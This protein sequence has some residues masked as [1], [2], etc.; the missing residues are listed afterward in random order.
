MHSLLIIIEILIIREPAIFPHK[1]LHVGP[2]I[3]KKH[4]LIPVRI[5][6]HLIV[7]QQHVLL[8]V[9]IHIPIVRAPFILRHL[10][11]IVFHHHL[12]CKVEI[13]IVVVIARCLS[14]CELLLLI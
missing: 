4:I 14:L 9:L 7:I 1:I 2:I 13:P 8:K 11:V 3:I 6:L 5:L 12:I 10:I